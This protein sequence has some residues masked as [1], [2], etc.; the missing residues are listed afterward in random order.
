MIIQSRRVWIAGQF[1]PAQLQVEGEKI[2]AVLEYGEMAADQDYGMIGL[3]RDLLIFI[4]MELMVMIPTMG[5][6]KDCGNG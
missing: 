1:I 5:N 6:R 4:P 2:K 3:F